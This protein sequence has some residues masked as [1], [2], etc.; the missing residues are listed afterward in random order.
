[1][2]D[3]KTWTALAAGLGA[4]A[5][6]GLAAHFLGSQGDHTKLAAIV[7]PP[8]VRAAQL[9]KRIADLEAKRKSASPEEAAKI[10]RVI[11]TLEGTLAAAEEKI[12]KR[13][14]ESQRTRELRAL[15]EKTRK[16]ELK[17]L[18]GSAWAKLGQP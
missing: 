5:A 8:E 13:P 7:D 14:T 9:K 6:V 2:D 12:E 1:M 4:I 16:L 3:S 11:Q 15:K 17:N 18:R 10:L